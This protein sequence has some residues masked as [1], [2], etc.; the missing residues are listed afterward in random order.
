MDPPLSAPSR[1]AGVM[2]LYFGL[3][4]TVFGVIATI[5]LEYLRDRVKRLEEKIDVIYPV[6]AVGALDAFFGGEP[7]E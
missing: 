2:E 5:R 6:A 7:L 1:L 4:G 3:A